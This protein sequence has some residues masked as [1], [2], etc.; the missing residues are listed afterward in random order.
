VESI[1]DCGANDAGNVSTEG[2]SRG[3]LT[4]A[5]EMPFTYQVLLDAGQIGAAVA[6]PVVVREVLFHGSGEVPR[7]T[8]IV[9]LQMAG[10]EFEIRVRFRCWVT[11]RVVANQD[12]RVGDLLASGV[13]EGE[14]L[15]EGFEYCSTHRVVRTS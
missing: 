3:E 10:E 9:R 14:D 12:L 2:E 1:V 7:G 8:A 11:V 5:S 6:E 13:A 4:R 15:P